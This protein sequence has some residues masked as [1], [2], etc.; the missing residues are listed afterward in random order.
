MYCHICKDYIS[1]DEQCINK[2]CLYIRNKIKKMSI[3][4][5]YKLLQQE[6]Y[7][8]HIL[9]KNKKIIY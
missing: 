7:I 1:E 2:K 3:D 5:L 4:E 9:Y 8:R 6:Y